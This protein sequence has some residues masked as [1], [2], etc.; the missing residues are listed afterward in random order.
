[1]P[2]AWNGAPMRHRHGLLRTIEAWERRE[3]APSPL[4]ATWIAGH[5]AFNV[6]TPHGQV[7]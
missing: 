3:G 4:G 5:Q 2:A 1:M 7:G 6:A